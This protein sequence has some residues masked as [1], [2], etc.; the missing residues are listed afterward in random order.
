MHAIVVGA[1]GLVG[2]ELTKQLLE[3]SYYDKITLVIRRYIELEHEKLDIQIVDFKDIHK[4]WTVFTCDHLYYCLG[5]TKSQT[6]KGDEYYKVEHDYCIN[7]A[8]ISHHNKVKKFLYLSSAGASSKSWFNYL[9]IKGTVEEQ[10]MQIGF[11][12]LHIFRPFVLMGKR[13]EFR[14]GESIARLFLRMFNFMMVGFL[15]SIKGMPAAQ[16]AKAMIHNA[17]LNAKGTF[18]HTNRSIHEFFPKK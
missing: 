10:L 18:I 2:K 6:P 11:P 14:W 3:D 12:Y 16:M 13:E 7:V 4:D 17:K 1:N 15:R 8:K 5:T 9:K